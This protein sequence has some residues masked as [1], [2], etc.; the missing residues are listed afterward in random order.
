MSQPAVKRRGRPPNQPR[1]LANANRP[2]K[3]M[4]RPEK[5]I[6]R[7]L[8]PRPHL[9]GATASTNSEVDSRASSETTDVSKD[10]RTTISEHEQEAGLAL[11][12]MLNGS[13]TSDSGD[14]GGETY[15]IPT[16]EEMEQEHREI[17]GGNDSELEDL[18]PSVGKG[19]T[20]EA[21]NDEDEEDD[22]DTA[23]I[24]EAET[25][26]EMSFSVPIANKMVNIVEVSTS[27]SWSDF[28]LTIS[29][30]MDIPSKQLCLGYHLG[31]EPKN[32][33]TRVLNS[34]AQ[35][36]KLIERVR[37]SHKEEEGKKGKKKKIATHDVYLID[38]RVSSKAKKGAKD[39]KK[40]TESGS[41]GKRKQRDNDSGSDNDNNRDGNQGRA[42]KAAGSGDEGETDWVLR[43]QAKFQ[44]ADHKGTCWPG[45][46]KQHFH[47]THANISLWAAMIQGKGLQGHG[48][49]SKQ[50][51][52]LPPQPTHHGM[53]G[54]VAKTTVAAENYIGYPHP[55]SIPPPGY[56]PYQYPP[57]MTPSRSHHTRERSSS[58]AIRDTLLSSEANELDD[59]GLFPLI[60]DWLQG[61]EAGTY[62]KDGHS[63]TIHGWSLRDKGY[64]HVHQF[65][66]LSL[67]DIIRLCPGILEGTAR[68]LLRQANITVNKKKREIQKEQKGKR[69]RKN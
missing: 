22:D 55:Y 56:F 50:C 43:L 66:E 27:A 68:V 52:R 1:S 29:N 17:F 46:R 49:A 58:P 19:L 32:S 30:Q 44:C 23:S 10:T 33:D 37:A 47:L 35:W 15:Q 25:D 3:D 54:P 26:F 14:A 2:S 28:Q 7:Q 6:T 11:L 40:T 42:G 36:L 21:D 57:M 34:H 8:R 41:G 53:N 59:P 31:A 48:S 12:D 9:L 51:G 45:Q 63:F 64:T 69:S 62:G 13:H 60:T 4:D 67:D 61:L 5:E 20:V 38:S 18:A 65:A 39:S 24:S 16:I